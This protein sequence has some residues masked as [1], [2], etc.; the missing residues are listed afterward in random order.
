MWLMFI[1]EYTMSNILDFWPINQS[2]N[3]SEIDSHMVA[4]NSESMV[5]HPTINRVWEE[6]KFGLYSWI[7]LFKLTKYYI[8]WIELNWIYLPRWYG[9]CLIGKGYLRQ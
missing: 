1:I 6:F 3:Q 9:N 7:T 8:Y 5:K 2:N 4:E